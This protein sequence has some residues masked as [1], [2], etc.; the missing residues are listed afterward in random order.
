MIRN[1]IK[2]RVDRNNRAF[3]S[4]TILDIKRRVVTTGNSSAIQFFKKLF[5]EGFLM[6]TL[7]QTF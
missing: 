2:T 6:N 3:A 4:L 1:I 7:Q 5:L